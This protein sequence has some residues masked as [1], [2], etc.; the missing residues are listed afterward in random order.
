MIAARRDF[1]DRASLAARLAQDVSQQLV[2]AVAS[3]GSALLAVSGGTTPG[4]FFER[5]SRQPIDWSRVTVTLVDERCVPEDNERSNA[6]LVRAHLLADFAAVAKFV[7]LF[8]S[9]AAATKLGRFD[10]VILGMGTDGHTASFFP[11]ADR[12]ADALGSGPAPRIIAITAPSAGEPR[13]TFTLR[14]LLDAGFIVLHIEGEEK[15]RVL[16]RALGPGPVEEMPIRAFLRSTEP[17]IV[18]WAP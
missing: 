16:K 8:G 18:Y 6:R 17:I 10:A 2:A 14:S 12:L 9:Q 1:A 3:K 5:L 7:P 11:Q 15:A 4:L 13:L